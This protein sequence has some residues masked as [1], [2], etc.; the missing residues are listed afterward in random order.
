MP[1][2]SERAQ[3]GVRTSNL[4]PEQLLE[5]PKDLGWSLSVPL[6]SSVGLIANAIQL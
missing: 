6:T 1:P 5:S 4:G 2:G 3:Q